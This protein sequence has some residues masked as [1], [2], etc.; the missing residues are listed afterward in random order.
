MDSCF[1]VVVV[2]TAENSKKKIKHIIR[3]LFNEEI[4]AW[5]LVFYIRTLKMLHEKKN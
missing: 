3:F 5:L 2:F 1:L 4:I